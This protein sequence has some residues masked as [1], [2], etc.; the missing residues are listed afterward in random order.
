MQRKVSQKNYAAEIRGKTSSN[1]LVYAKTQNSKLMSC[2]TDGGTQGNKTP[3][4][5]I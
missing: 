4:G 3:F 2:E 5:V 1:K